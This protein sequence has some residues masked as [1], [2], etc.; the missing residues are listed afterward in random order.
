LFQE[1]A[2]LIVAINNF[3]GRNFF[4]FVLAMQDLNQT[5]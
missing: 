1:A 3:E 4:W 5:L 2:L